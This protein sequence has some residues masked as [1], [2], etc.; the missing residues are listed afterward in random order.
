MTLY[1]YVRNK[2]DIVA[3]MQDAILA[4]ILV[5]DGACAAAGGTPSPRSPGGPGTCSWPTPGRWR[6]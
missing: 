3:L 6:R 4:D 1:Y 5:P 2:T